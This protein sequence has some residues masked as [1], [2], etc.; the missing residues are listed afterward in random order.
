MNVVA[1]IALPAAPIA[2]TLLAVG[3]GFG[4][5]RRHCS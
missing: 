2:T 4:G 5:L 3:P 1:I